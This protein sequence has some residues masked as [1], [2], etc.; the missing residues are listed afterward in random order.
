MCL[1]AVT[2]QQ[3]LFTESLLSN[4]SIR[5]NT[6]YKPRMQR[7]QEYNDKWQEWDKAYKNEAAARQMGGGVG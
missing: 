3:L 6:N 5:Q 7:E 4:S 1:P 2:K